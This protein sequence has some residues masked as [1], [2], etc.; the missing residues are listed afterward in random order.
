MKKIFSLFTLVLVVLLVTGC[1]S[2]YELAL[3]TDFGPVDDKS[4][5]QGA[6]EGI[7]QYADE[8]NVSYKY[9]R[10]AEDSAKARLDAI[11]I[12][13]KGGA[14]V[15]VCP[16]FSFG[17]PVFDAQSEFPDVKIILL[18]ADP[19][20][21]D[22]SEFRIDDNVMSIYYAEEQAGFLVG[23]AAV[24]EGSHDLG[25]FGGISVPA[26]VRFG[27][28]YLEGA[29]YAAREDD[30]DVSVKYK[31][32]GTFDAKPEN[33]TLAASWYAGGV[34][35]IFVAAGGAVNSAISAAEESPGKTV[36]GCN[37]DQKDLSEVILTSSLKQLSDSVYSAIKEFYAGDFRG[38]QIVNL[39]AAEG[40]V[41]MPNDFSRF[42][43][44]TKAEYEAV[45]SKIIS[46]EIVV[47]KSHEV[48]IPAD[49]DLERTTVTVVE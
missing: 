22:W 11:R 15:V 42:S 5:N 47:T 27:V 44:F 17:E 33:K 37:V 7:E 3:V 16:G 31:Y 43:N 6:W 10:P 20:N 19:H 12:A 35:T 8:F 34:E 46:G 1:G 39:T 49:L 45:L 25:F 40:G 32:L 13:V 30:V 28:G 23:Y 14:K 36:I 18:D 38:G 21:A 41:A 4:F 48:A 29:E 26:V 2:S 9:Y 24:K